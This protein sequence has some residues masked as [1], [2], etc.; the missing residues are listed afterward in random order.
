[1]EYLYRLCLGSGFVTLFAGVFL[2]IGCEVDNPN[3]NG[4]TCGNGNLDLTIGEQCDAPASEDCNEDCTLPNCG[5]A[6]L[7]PLEQCDDGN[8]APGDGCSS[9]CRVECA[10]D[11]DCSALDRRVCTN[12]AC[13]PG[14]DA[15]EDCNEGTVCN[16]DDKFC[17]TAC[18]ADSDCPIQSICQDDG[19]CTFGCRSDEQCAALSDNLF[20]R[21][22]LEVD[23]GST[24]C[25]DSSECGPGE[26]CSSTD[27]LCCTRSYGESNG[28]LFGCQN[29]GDCQAGENCTRGRCQLACATNADC[30][31]SAY[32][33]SATRCERSC[34]VDGDCSP[35]ENC[36]LGLCVAG[37]AVD[38]DCGQGRIC[39]AGACIL[40]CDNNDD[41]SFDQECQPDGT[42]DVPGSGSLQCGAELGNRCV[43]ITESGVGGGN[44]GGLAGADAICK[45]RADASSLSGMSG[46]MWQAWLSH[47][48][49]SPSNRWIERAT[50]RYLK[51]NG[52][53]VANDFGDLASGGIDDPINVSENGT[54][55]AG[56]PVWTRTDANGAGQ[57]CTEGDPNSADCD[58]NGWTADASFTTGQIGDSAR[59]T[60][61][62]TEGDPVNAACDNTDVRLFCFEM[63]TTTSTTTTIPMVSTTLGCGEEGCAGSTTTTLPA[64]CMSGEDHCYVF[65]TSA[66]FDGDFGGG[67]S[68][69]H[70]A[71]Q[72]AADTAG[73]V[74]AG[75]VWRAWITDFSGPGNPS[76]WPTFSSFPYI[77]RDGTQIASSFEDLIELPGILDNPIDQDE[78]G[79]PLV[80]TTLVWTNT[81]VR[82][83]RQTIIGTSSFTDTCD[84]WNDNSSGRTGSVGNANS[85]DDAWTTCNTTACGSPGLDRGCD[86]SYR[87]YCFEQ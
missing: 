26:F 15:D 34:Q 2:L 55:V 5:D 66:T 86:N 21:S 76:N 28:C 22:S 41:C 62:W 19:R 6:N 58:C 44:L 61:R 69:H 40:G 36:E 20:C 85:V 4:A 78:F 10:S 80:G 35:D 68:G 23:C 59:A 1:M 48:G 46:R 24:D 65:A 33:C 13:V 64:R 63:V 81:N 17:V 52:A 11:V 83:D 71:C 77:L 45:A 27:D 39:A 49:N 30:P 12:G 25:D 14:C 54:A 73:G 75:R 47:D 9:G 3:G 50:V 84:N 74:F 57:F 60:I 67:Q 79:N 18:A 42:C 53:Q 16:F 37:C 38:D 56:G 82:G 51:T 70:A 43:F 87:L 72:A 32:E 31:S 29:D 7:D 8:Q